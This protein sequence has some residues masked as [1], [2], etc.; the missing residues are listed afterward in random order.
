MTSY[1]KQ[2][3]PVLF[4]WSHWYSWYSYITALI[5]CLSQYRDSAR[6]LE[7]HNSVTSLLSSHSVLAQINFLQNHSTSALRSPTSMN[8]YPSHSHKEERNCITNP[9]AGRIIR[10]PVPQPICHSPACRHLLSKAHIRILYMHPVTHTPHCDIKAV[11]H[12]AR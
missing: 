4:F 11:S 2:I 12:S 8:N 7:P 5:I 6:T 3:P 9:S 1:K 10:R